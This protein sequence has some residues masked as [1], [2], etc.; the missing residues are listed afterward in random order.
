MTLGEAREV[1]ARIWCDPEMRDQPMDAE[2]AEY[3]ARLIHW[4]VNVKIP[5]DQELED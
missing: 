3:I 2:L 4:T 1:A 5:M